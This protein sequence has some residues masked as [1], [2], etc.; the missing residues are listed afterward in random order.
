MYQGCRYF[1]RFKGCSVRHLQ[2]KEKDEKHN[3]IF[4]PDGPTNITK[5]KQNE[6]KKNKQQKQKQKTKTKT[7]T[8]N[9]NK[10][11]K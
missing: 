7:K 6:T 5:A 1:A 10:N 3:F 11:K 4:F 8:K 9:K 2:H